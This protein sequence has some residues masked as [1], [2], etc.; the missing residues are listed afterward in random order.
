V[1]KASKSL[2]L[3]CLFFQISGVYTVFTKN[4][5]AYTL[6]YAHLFLVT[7]YLMNQHYSRLK[8]DD[9]DLSGCLA[10]QPFA[11]KKIARHQLKDDDEDL[12]GCLVSQPFATKKIARQQ[13]SDDED[14]SG[15]LASQP[16]ATKKIAGHQF[17]DDDEDLSGFLLSAPLQPKKTAEI[18]HRQHFVP[19]ERDDIS[20]EIRISDDIEVSGLVGYGQYSS[21]ATNSSLYLLPPKRRR[22]TESDISG[23]REPSDDN[24][25]DISGEIKTSDDTGSDWLY[26]N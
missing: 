15:C 20:G 22:Y 9:E 6:T 11:T 7:E 3:T 23:E 16:F 10:S 1:D 18:N 17:S 8:D 2:S 25:A 21:R 14:L 5:Y 4:K 24:E 19:L 12:S 13:F 26:L